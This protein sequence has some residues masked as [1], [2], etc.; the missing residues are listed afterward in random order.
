MSLT[1]IEI[2]DGVTH[3][4]H[5]QESGTIDSYFLGGV[6]QPYGKIE[7]VTMT[8]FT[9]SDVKQLNTNI[10]LP[11]HADVINNSGQVLRLV[12]SHVK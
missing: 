7:G 1:V 10:P 3:Q 11:K 12:I 4:V 9:G 5:E 8:F 6:L 2:A